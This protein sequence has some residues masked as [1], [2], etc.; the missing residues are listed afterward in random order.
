VGLLFYRA[1]FYV[2]ALGRFLSADTLVPEPGNPQSLNRYTYVRN[3]PLN[4]IDPSGHKECDLQWG[5]DVV[6][7]LPKSKPFSPWPDPLRDQL[8]GDEA[9]STR[10]YRAIE[11]RAEQ[12]FLQELVVPTSGDYNPF[13]GPNTLGGAG[14]H[15][16]VDSKDNRV[17]KPIYATTYGV[18]V[19]VGQSDFG[20]HVVIEHD[21]L[22]VKFYSVYAH[23]DTQSV[24]EGDIV[25][26]ATQIGTMG[27]GNGNA[28]LHFEV[29]TPEN[30]D[31][32]PDADHDPF[33]GQV[34]WP[35]TYS[36]LKRNFVDLGPIFGYYVN[37]LQPDLSYASWKENSP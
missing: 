17:G 29:R 31:F 30:V 27:V 26:D 14:R 9:Y 6:P 11:R 36:S 19:S 16:A 24:A 12:A 3:R 8:L 1:R 33:N 37:A 22:G 4:Y 25:D 15:A 32:T 35:E 28:H 20:N 5:C 34:W 10:H 21:V 23:L 18:V 13:G 7:I 2:P